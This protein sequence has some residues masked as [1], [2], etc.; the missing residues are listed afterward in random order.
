MQILSLDQIRR[1]AGV[2][3]AIGLWLHVPII[4]CVAMLT[5]TEIAAPTVLAAILAA[6]A[7]L[8]WAVNRAGPASRHVAAVALVGMASILVWQAAGPWQ[9]D[10]HMYYF[11]ALAMLAAFCDWRVIVMAA[12][13]TALHHLVLN[14][15]L[16]YAVFPGG[17]SLGRVL[18]HAVIVVL[19]T[20]ALVALTISIERLFRSMT[21]AVDRAAAKETEAELLR[22]QRAEDERRKGEQDRKAEMAELADAFENSVRRVAAEVSV[23]ATEMTR[24]SEGIARSIA[25]IRQ[26][27]SASG[28]TV[29]GTSSS[30]DRVSTALEKLST[31]AAMI[32]SEVERSATAAG[33]ADAA[34]RSTDETA[35]GLADAARKIGDVIALINAIAAQTNLLALNATIE[36]ARAGEAGKGFTVVANEV[37]SLAGQTARA[38]QE[39]EAQIT[40]IQSI[41][42]MVLSSIGSIGERVSE[43]T[44][45]AAQITLVVEEQHETMERIAGEASMVAAGVRDVAEAAAAISGT[46]TEAATGAD[47]VYEAAQGLLTHSGALE[48]AAD[49]FLARV[50]AG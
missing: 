30:A 14:F 39:I 38:T 29:D 32:R 24:A 4:A 18:L 28:E 10:L 44:E 40:A 21:D 23:A 7:S 9:I 31:S 6:A 5:G 36:A 1:T 35:R 43:M 41:A 22:Q 12:G 20:C 46:A 34:V 3:F 16:P 19:E 45:I 13:A 49:S 26:Q 17:A 15:V 42:E 48:Q 25:A 37:K 33:D 50:R 2:A 11:A 27:A 47:R 8:S